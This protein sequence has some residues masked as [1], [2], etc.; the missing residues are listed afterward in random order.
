MAI[1][2][3]AKPFYSEYLKKTFRRTNE[4][5]IVIDPGH[6]GHDSGAR[7][8]KSYEKDN[9]LKVGMRMRT[10]LRE[11]GYQ[12]IL[13]RDKDVY[14][15]LKQRYNM[16]NNYKAVIFISL[17]DNSATATATGFETFTSNRAGA[18]TQRLRNCIHDAIIKEIGIR[19]RGKKRSDF[20]VVRW[21]HMPAVLIEYAF[22]SNPSDERI[23]INEVEM[24]ARTTVQGINNFFGVTN[25]KERQKKPIVKVPS[26]EME[27][28]EEMK[29]NGTT[30]KD[31]MHLNNYA[32]DQ[33]I[34]SHRIATRSELEQ[35]KK[36]P[37]WTD[38]YNKVALED[39]TD[40]EL[41]NKYLSY[42]ARKEYVSLNR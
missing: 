11:Y 8:S 13:T 2:V 1:N 38:R 21:T 15:T 4:I 30:R 33:G 18:Q 7:G 9:V 22:V 42:L 25:K 37:G 34:F 32:V 20:A 27:V 36:T 29:L 26:V 6:G 17:H 35:V 3:L 28:L 41:K 40:D 16:A 10:M 31:I 14:L 39:M 5:L 24:L 23:L 12:V 19:D